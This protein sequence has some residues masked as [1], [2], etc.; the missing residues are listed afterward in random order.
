MPQLSILLD[1][2]ASA[3]RAGRAPA[4]VE[5]QWAWI[6]RAVSP[7][8]VIDLRAMFAAADTDGGGTLSREEVAQTCRLLH[9]GL[10]DDSIDAVVRCAAAAA[11]HLRSRP[12]AARGR[13]PGGVSAGH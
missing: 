7:T 3:G 6:M 2:S 1:Q 5:E 10:P 4:A 11:E 13:T 12:A 8:L 9:R